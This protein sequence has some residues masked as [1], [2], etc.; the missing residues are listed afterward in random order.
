MTARALQIRE[1]RMTKQVIDI[2]RRRIVPS[3][4]THDQSVALKAINTIHR[5]NS[6]A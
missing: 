3:L 1:Q 5:R 2:A 6:R 4:Q